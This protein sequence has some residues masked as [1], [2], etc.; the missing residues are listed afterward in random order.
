MGHSFLTNNEE[1]EK[2]LLSNGI[3]RHLGWSHLSQVAE[4]IV[5][6]HGQSL[7]WNQQ[8]Y[9]EVEVYMDMLERMPVGKRPLNQ[10]LGINLDQA[11]VQSAKSCNWGT[12]QAQM[13]GQKLSLEYARALRDEL[14]SKR[15][16][17]ELLHPMGVESTDEFWLV[18]CPSSVLL[19]SVP[20][21]SEEAW[22]SGVSATSRMRSYPVGFAGLNPTRNKRQP[23]YLTVE[24]IWGIS[25][26]YKL[27]VLENLSVGASIM[28]DL[29][30]PVVEPNLASA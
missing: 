18:I 6:S 22:C 3:P 15:E 4:W 14:A 30:T 25:P 7:K 29:I 24:E 1:M 21:L 12:T 8:C 2:L 19:A 28:G 16:C 11:V 13:K 26:Q 10:V 17:P 27:W 9:G 5:V 23:D 20:M